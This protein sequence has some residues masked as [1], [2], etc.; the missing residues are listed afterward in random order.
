MLGQGCD[1]GGD[2]ARQASGERSILVRWE[3]V[4]FRNLG[5]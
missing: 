5:C 2:S 3:N 4:A 1:G